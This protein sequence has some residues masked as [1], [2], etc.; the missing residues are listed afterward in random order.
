MKFS[1][2]PLG[3]QGNPYDFEKRARSGGT[4]K[5]GEDI[6]SGEDEQSFVDAL[7]D[8]LEAEAEA[9]KLKGARDKD[10]YDFQALVQKLVDSIVR[11]K[12]G[13]KE[14]TE[15]LKNLFERTE[16]FWEDYDDILRE[17]LPAGKEKE[18]AYKAFR[19]VVGD[20]IYSADEKGIKSEIVPKTLIKQ[21]RPGAT[22]GQKISYDRGGQP[23]IKIERH[24]AAAKGE[25]AGKAPLPLKK[26]KR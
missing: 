23:H 5:F 4:G 16:K 21:V 3:D 15:E 14:K 8:R 22:R 1:E 12:S 26:V 6:P 7:S 18:L 19:Q 2:K 11:E 13:Q 24:P 17:K 10:P 9:E 25:T 20:V